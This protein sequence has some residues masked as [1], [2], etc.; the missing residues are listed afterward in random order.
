[1]FRFFRHTQLVSL[2]LICWLLVLLVPTTRAKLSGAW[3]SHLN[4]SREPGRNYGSWFVDHK[5]NAAS[6]IQ[7]FPNNQKVQIYA[8]QNNQTSRELLKRYPSNSLILVVA[9]REEIDSLV[10][11]RIDGPLINPQYPT[12]PSIS[13]GEGL[14]D[15]VESKAT[16]AKKIRSP[17]GD[18]NRFLE[19]AKRGRQLE[20][21]NS[22]FTWMHLYGLCATR[23]DHEARSLLAEATRQSSYD[24][25]SRDHVLNTLAVMRLANGSPVSPRDQ[26]GTMNTLLLPELS[27]FRQTCR[28]LM[29]GVIADRQK[30]K[31]ARALRTAFE[32]MLLSRTMRRESYSLI[33]SIVGNACES[34]A[35]GSVTIPSNTTTAARRARWRAS[36][37]AFQ[38][39]PTMLYSYARSQNRLDIQ[40]KLDQEWIE[41]ARWSGLSK[42]IVDQNWTGNSTAQRLTILASERFAAL[43][44]KALP[45]VILLEIIFSILSSRFGDETKATG[46]LW[47]GVFIGT[48]FLL[49]AM[50]CD[51]LIAWQS[52]DPLMGDEFEWS[53]IGSVG[54]LSAAPSWVS[55]GMAS[56]MLCLA[57]NR[58]V[59]WQKEQLGQRISLRSRVKTI[60]APPEDG[61]ARFDFGWV[62]TLVARSTGWLLLMGGIAWI[63]YKSGDTGTPLF[64]GIREDFVDP[65][66]CLM[67]LGVLTSVLL[68]VYA[69]CVRPR[70]RQSLR[71]SL[72]L[73]SEGL[74]GVF[75]TISVSYAVVAFAIL[76][77]A[78]QHERTFENAMKRGEVAIARAKTGL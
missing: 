58:A 59:A 35:L 74:I 37:S 28:W 10:A 78:L 30:G 24:D 71:L 43:S 9:L 32:L 16:I 60:F 51:A 4:V 47:S 26:F 15:P 62:F 33:N 36:L 65:G 38:N 46:M 6:F 20:P 42:V 77:F 34:I 50:I 49:A 48:T 39:D 44:L 21:D 3:T 25:H 63:C 53:Y 8:A 72:R 29:E 68:S 5:A 61:L 67:I 56:V 41:I 1:M 76:P 23:Q 69:W 54:L 52:P 31:H 73:I 45:L 55:Y 27:R 17:R 70:R 40:R 66:V 13:P 14:S 2:A 57:L 7:R 22:F 18:W 11:D 75:V 12:P 64:R 19:L